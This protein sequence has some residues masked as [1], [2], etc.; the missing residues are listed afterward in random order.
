LE[1]TG[2]VEKKADFDAD[3]GA[4]AADGE[5]G[6]EGVEATTGNGE[7]T[8]TEGETAA[9]GE[10]ATSIVEAILGDRVVDAADWSDDPENA[11][12]NAVDEDSAS[13]DEEAGVRVGEAGVIREFGSAVVKVEETNGGTDAAD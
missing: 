9:D 11:E 2:D 5:E 7:V 4:G 12:T 1:A 13:G 6:A 3:G 10:A 8:A